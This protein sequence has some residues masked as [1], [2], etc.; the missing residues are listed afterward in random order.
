MRQN[1][2]EA[3]LLGWLRS[4]PDEMLRVRPVLSV[5]YAGILLTTG[6]IEGVE[7]RLGDAERWLDLR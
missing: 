2:Q 3:T 5:I 1:R 4:L 7:A 6:E